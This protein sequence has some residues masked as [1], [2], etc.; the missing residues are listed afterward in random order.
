MKGF[1]ERVDGDRL[2]SFFIRCFHNTCQLGFTL[3]RTV[4]K[5]K[6]VYDRNAMKKSITPMLRIML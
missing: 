3:R 6:K 1:N 5:S 2:F 4:H